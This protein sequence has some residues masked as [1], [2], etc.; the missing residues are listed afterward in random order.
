MKSSREA[1]SFVNAGS[2]VER[3]FDEILETGINYFDCCELPP[4]AVPLLQDTDKAFH[5]ENWRLQRGSSAGRAGIMR[6]INQKISRGAKRRDQSSF[7]QTLLPWV[8]FVHTLDSE[9]TGEPVIF[10][11]QFAGC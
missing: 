2:P 5:F 7:S 4:N 8:R 10:S 11:N 1:L 9:K 3:A 6:V